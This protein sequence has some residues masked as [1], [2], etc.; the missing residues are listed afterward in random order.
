MQCVKLVN[1]HQICA[2]LALKIEKKRTA[3]NAKM[4]NMR[5]HQPIS[6]LI[7]SLNVL[8]VINKINV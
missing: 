8:H 6:V 7:A 2:S 1:K 5:I 3:V 4:E